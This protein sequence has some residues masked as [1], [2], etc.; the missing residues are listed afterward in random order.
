MQD[1]L[2]Y[3]LRW[4]PARPEEPE[5]V[6]K[7]AEGTT[8]TPNAGLQLGV[9][10]PQPSR[11]TGA[12]AWPATSLASYCV[13]QSVLVRIYT[14]DCHALSRLSYAPVLR[15]YFGRSR[16]SQPAVHVLVQVGTFRVPRSLLLWYWASSLQLPVHTAHKEPFHVNLAVG[17]ETTGTRQCGEG[18]TGRDARSPQGA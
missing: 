7:R 18:V 9:P 17:V 10:L 15:A 2:G 14:A 8:S 4:G 12:R 5:P 11:V 3:P 13:R 16:P 6:S 1:S